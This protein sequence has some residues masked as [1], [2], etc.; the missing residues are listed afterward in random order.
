[1]KIQNLLKT[2]VTYRFRPRGVILGAAGSPD[3]LDTANVRDTPENI[4]MARE[5]ESRGAV[6]ILSDTKKQAGEGRISPP[7]VSSGKPAGKDGEESG[8]SSGEKPGDGVQ[9]NDNSD[10]GSEGKAGEKPSKKQTSK[11]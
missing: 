9:K 7:E 5:L 3:G 1:M 11:K 10:A 4:E 6:K 2:D 8:K